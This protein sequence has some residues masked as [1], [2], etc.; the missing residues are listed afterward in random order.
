MRGRK[1]KPTKL[2]ELAGNPGKRAL[3]K[4]EPKPVGALGDAPKW[5]TTEQR[6][7]WVYAMTHAPRGLLRKIDRGVLATWV[8]AEDLHR[9]AIME[10]NTLGALVTKTK[11]GNVTQSPFLP[12]INRQA[13]IMLKAAAEL[14]F[15]PAARPRLATGIAPR[16]DDQEIDAADE[17]SAD[18][19]EELGKHLASN[20][21]RLN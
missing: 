5:M 20:P 4:G 17:I 15:S 1:L 12:I 2:K 6:A 9:Q 7:G 13:L 11:N 19:G 16:G 18:S 21:S 14:G 3:P 10:Q 8:I